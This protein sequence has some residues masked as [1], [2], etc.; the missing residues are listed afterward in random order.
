MGLYECY[1]NN[2]YSYVTSSFTALLSNAPTED[3][4]ALDI[5]QH[6]FVLLSSDVHRIS[7]TCLLILMFDSH[8]LK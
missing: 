7:A 3:T 6:Y 2:I 1:F 5:R 8:N 4:K